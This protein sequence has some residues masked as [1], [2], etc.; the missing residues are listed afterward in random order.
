MKPCTCIY[1]PI[2]GSDG[3]TYSNECEF[4]SFQFSR[5]GDHVSSDQSKMSKVAAT[6]TGNST[7]GR[8]NGISHLISM[9]NGNEDGFGN[10]F[11]TTYTNMDAFKRD[12]RDLYDKLFGNE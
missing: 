7:F 12:H 1:K 5:T 2:C 3:R 10:H 8:V 6:L 11:I 4:E 9:D